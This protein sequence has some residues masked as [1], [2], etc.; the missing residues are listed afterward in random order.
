MFIYEIWMFTFMDWTGVDLRA[1]LSNQN[2][3]EELRELI[4][5]LAESANYIARGIR[6]IGRGGVTSVNIHG[7]SQMKLD[8]WADV[9]ILKRLNE[10][11]GFGVFEFASEEQDEVIVIGR[12]KLGKQGR[13]SVTA[14]PLDGSSLIGVNSSIGSI[15]GIHDGAIISGRPS[16][17]GLVAAAY[18]LYGPTTTLVVGVNGKTHEFILDEARNWVLQTESIRMENKGSIY[19][20]GVL[21]RDWTRKHKEY[22][23]RLENEGYKLRYGGAFVSDFNSVLMKKGG[24]RF[25]PR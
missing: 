8:V 24:W 14:D 9:V 6:E 22:I 2:V 7:D 13:Y 12:N 11:T 17:E 16:R 18:A 5:H 3:D 15:F 21:R 4:A 19:G 10:E 1:F 23:E 20:S 25:L